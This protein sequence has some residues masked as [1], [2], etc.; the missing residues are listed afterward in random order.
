[1]SEPACANCRFYRNLSAARAFG[2]CR[3]YP[4]SVITYDAE[5]GENLIIKGDVYPRVSATT[6]CGEHRGAN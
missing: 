6:W 2:E 5:D 4:P 1:M 3:R